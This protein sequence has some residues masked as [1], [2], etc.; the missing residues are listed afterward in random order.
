MRKASGNCI[1]S[2][3]SAIS[4]GNFADRSLNC[5]PRSAPSSRPSPPLAPIPERA[6]AELSA[7]HK[8]INAMAD[9]ADKEQARKALN[10]RGNRSAYLAIREELLRA[11][12]SPSQLDEQLCGSG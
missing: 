5:R 6:L 10:E 9:G 8:R 12:Y 4:T 3:V 2:A 11:V 1:C 7:D